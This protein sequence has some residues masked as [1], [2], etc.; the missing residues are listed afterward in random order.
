LGWRLFLR[1]DVYHLTEQGKYER[2][3]FESGVYRSRVIPGFFLNPQWLWGEPRPKKLNILR[4]LGL[5]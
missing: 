2:L 4:E 5:L 1:I 3:P